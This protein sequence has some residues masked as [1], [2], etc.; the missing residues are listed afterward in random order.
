M[1][2]TVR[3]MRDLLPNMLK[4]R[5]GWLLCLAL[6]T[7]AG[8][9]AIAPWA[10]REWQFHSHMRVA[11]VAFER[12]VADN[13]V[14][15]LQAAE[16]L[17][18]DSAEVQYLLG[19]ANRKAGHLEDCSPHLKRARELGWPEKEVRFQQ[20][21]LAFQAGHH[22][23][24]AD[25]KQLISL[26]MS[27]EVAEDTYE[28]LAVGYLADYRISAARMVVGHWLR[29]RPRRVRPLLL[30]AEILGA[31]RLFHE[32]IAQY[33][34]VLEIEPDNYP[35]HL[36]LAYNLL[37]EHKVDAAL[38]H[39]RWC[40]TQWPGDISPPLGVAE[41]YRHQGKFAEAAQVLQELLK[42][43][44][45]A[46]QRAYVAGELG[47]LRHQTGELKEAIVLLTESVE[48]NPYDP[49]N[50]YALALC[51]AREGRPKEAQ[52]HSER[53][54]ALEKL[55]RQLSDVELIMLN[56]PN[57]AQSRYDAGVLLSKLGN[58]KAAAAMMLAT[59]RWDPRHS[60]A[61]TELAK[62]YHE[63]GREDLS[64][65]H[66]VLNAEFAAADAAGRHEAQRA[67]GTE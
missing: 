62:Y 38:E 63:I 49:Q 16:K 50:H 51:L 26:P 48:G 65:E 53:Y 42:Q 24:E 6:A 22:R 15:E 25:I 61:H 23:A 18:P 39:F 37:D 1:G 55:R 30:S 59:L 19:V 43:P 44:M 66:E 10:R 12:L 36:G 67:A 13:A 28:A 17:K 52:L 45:A 27:D 58:S 56:E 11:R 4:R 41:C 57:D 60:G 2:L 64:H 5:R 21:L 35:A 9:A 29:W 14:L 20:L 7:A 34:R 8:V 47:K 40:G 31:S 33:E 3:V 32:Q 54:K 46:N